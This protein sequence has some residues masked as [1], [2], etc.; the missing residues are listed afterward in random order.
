MRIPA[1]LCLSRHGVYYFRQTSQANGKQ[2]AKKISLHTKDPFIAKSKAIQLLALLN[3]NKKDDMTIRKF[4]MNVN[5]NG[6]I[7][8]VT[9]K[10]DPDDITKL[11]VF[12]KDNPHLLQS[13]QT[14][15][16]EVEKVI[17][18]VAF[19]LIIKK[20]EARKKGTI[21][22]K[23]LYGYLQNIN[24]FREWAENQTGKKPFP[25]NL[26]DRKLISLYINHLRTLDITDR[27]IEKNYLMSLNGIFDFAKSIGDFPDITAPSRSHKLINKNNKT[28]KN[29]ESFSNDDLKAI[30]NPETLPTKAHPDQFWL[31]LLG[32]FTGARVSELAQIH[33]IDIGE[34]NNFYTISINDEEEKRVKSDAGKRIIPIHPI[35]IEIGFLDYLEDMKKFGGQ[36]F[37]TVRPDPYGYYGKEP[38]RRFA[39]Y[40]D[41]VGINDPAKVFHSFRSTANIK[42]MD[43]GIEEEKRCGFLGHDHNTVNTKNYGRKINKIKP[44][45]FF[46]NIIPVL[47]FNV[48]FSKLKY[49]KGMF[50]SFIYKDL[51]RVERAIQRKKHLDKIKKE[52]K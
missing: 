45:F 22:P 36:V 3:T 43:E 42:L 24:I 11:G 46:E 40:C 28:V 1:H 10:N 12:L 33:R 32:L 9:D 8:F 39:K 51:L 2:R 29:R 48:D 18:G 52:K 20:Y 38:S 17:D 23:T 16:A 37:P 50:D 44:E 14:T 31:P 49:K 47:N 21:A 25:I 6:A 19:D 26:A 34:K 35:L 30:F 13:K 15:K 27:T 4:E 7:T 41:D 5:P